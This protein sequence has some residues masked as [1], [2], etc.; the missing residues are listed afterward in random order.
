MVV[1]VG[2]NLLSCHGDI[3]HLPNGGSITG[4]LR[5]NIVVLVVCGRKTLGYRM[6][7]CCSAAWRN[8][9]GLMNL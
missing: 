4:A 7:K 3:S 6:D 8:D 2:V 9:T 5:V 1:A